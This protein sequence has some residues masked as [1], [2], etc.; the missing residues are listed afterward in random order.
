MPASSAGMTTQKQ[1]IHMTAATKD[2]FVKDISLAAFGRKEIDLAE[3]EMPGLMA[4][5]AEYGPKQPL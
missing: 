1:G 4:I 5:R 2:Y 3:T